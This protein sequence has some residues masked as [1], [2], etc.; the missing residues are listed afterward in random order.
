MLYADNTERM[1]DWSGTTAATFLLVAIIGLCLSLKPAFAAEDEAHVLILNGVDPYLPAY[2]VIDEAMRAGLTEET[3]RHIV[4]FSEALDAQRFPVDSL[5]AEYL[6]LFTTKYRALH[7]DVVVAV[8]RAALEFYRRHGAMLW[9]GAR[10]VYHGF[11]G[12]AV[13]RADLPPGVSAVLAFQDVK[14]TLEL[15]RRLQPNARRVLVVSGESD[16]DNRARQLAQATLTA[17]SRAS[18]VEYLTG[19]PVAELAARLAAVDRDTIVIYLSQFRDRDGRPYT[20]REVLREISSK[21]NA[22]VYGLAETYFGLGA[23]AGIVESYQARGRLVAAQVRAALDEQGSNPVPV[24]IETPHKCIADARVLKR[25]SLDV[26]R[27]PEGCEILFSA[28]PYWRQHIWRILAA[29][30][31]FGAQAALIVGLLLQNRR[32]RVAEFESRSRLSEIST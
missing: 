8:S 18:P 26:A 24:L 14:G 15:A 27:L 22:P 30:G 9:P 13:T 31:I 10:V 5:E 7:I 1:P 29:L 2:L 4:F 16:L 12:E 28:E 23:A 25:W 21:S 20:P 3:T 17:T 32:R 11:P 6:P 19:L